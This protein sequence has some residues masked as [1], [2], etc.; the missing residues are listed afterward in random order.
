MRAYEI[1]KEGREFP[2]TVYDNRRGET[3][4]VEDRGPKYYLRGTDYLYYGWTDK[5]DMAWNSEEE[6][7]AWL[8]KNGFQ[9][10]G[11]ESVEEGEVI[12]TKFQQKLGQKRGMFYNPDAE[13]PVSRK[14]GLPF[15]RFEVK[16]LSSGKTGTIIGVRTSGYREEVGTSQ[17]KLAHALAS[18]Y[19]AG[20]YS[21][22]TIE[23]VPLGDMFK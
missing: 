11:W 18:A 17:L 9:V 16:E 21:D 8:E 19:N 2:T 4:Y 12:G 22:Q 14:D 5:Y 3:M 23:K 15:D 13:P 1:L 7:K 6:M 20:G 10:I